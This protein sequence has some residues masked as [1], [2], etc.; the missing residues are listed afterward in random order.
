MTAPRPHSQP[1]TATPGPWSVSEA[2]TVEGE[3]MVVGGVGQG[4]GLIA[5]CT[6]KA[7]A[8]LICRLRE[9]GV[10]TSDAWQPIETAPHQ[11]RVLLGWRDWRDHQWC[12]EVG[13]A[14]TGQRFG[15]GYSNLSQHGSATHWQPIPDGP[16]SQLSSQERQT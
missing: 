15:N 4:F 13:P 9:C 3:Y 11:K 10:L 16:A 6:L 14:T 8:E 12:V 1:D 5:T 2:R 7:D